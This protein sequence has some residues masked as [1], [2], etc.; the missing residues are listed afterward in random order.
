MMSKRHHP[1]VV[2]DSIIGRTDE[3]SNMAD[4]QK[5]LPIESAR[6]VVI[7]VI[8]RDSVVVTR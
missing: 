7:K 3:E 6:D 8:N 2:G 1:A 4:D 5:R